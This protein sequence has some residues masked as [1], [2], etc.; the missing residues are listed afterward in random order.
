PIRR[1]MK[2]GELGSR[3]RFVNVSTETGRWSVSENC[4]TIRSKVPNGVLVGAAEGLTLAIVIFTSLLAESPWPIV[5]TLKRLKSI[6]PR[7]CD[8]I[9]GVEA[10]LKFDLKAFRPATPE[11]A[12]QLA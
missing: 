7:G 2:F 12:V 9:H 10:S 11:T 6:P 1:A 3:F 5:W 4:R 8:L